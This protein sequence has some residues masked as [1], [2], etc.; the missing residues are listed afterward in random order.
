MP[1]R[2]GERRAGVTGAVAIVFAFGAEKKSVQ[3][4]VL[5]HGVRCDRAGR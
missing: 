5:P 3:P 2:G 4:L 1:K